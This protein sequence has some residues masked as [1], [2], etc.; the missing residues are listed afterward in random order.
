[1]IGSQDTL[2]GSKPCLC[3]PAEESDVRVMEPAWTTSNGRGTCATSGTNVYTLAAQEKDWANYQNVPVS[4]G[5]GTAESR[6]AGKW[7][8]TAASYV[9]TPDASFINN[10]FRAYSRTRRGEIC[11]E[12]AGK[13][14]F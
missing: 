3:L 4:E 2:S 10:A 12:G 1:M 5:V 11:V 14:T 8:R 13:C 9:Y 6:R 7:Y